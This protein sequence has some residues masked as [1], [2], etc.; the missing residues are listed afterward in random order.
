MPRQLDEDEERHGPQRR[1]I[2]TGTVRPKEEMIRFVV[3]PDGAV[4]PDIDGKLPGRGIWLSAA[5]DVVNTAVA[6]K[7]FA[8]A[9]RAKVVVPDDMGDRLAALLAQRC[10]GCLGMARRAGRVVNGYEKVRALLRAKRAGVL[11]EA[12]DGA[13]GG[14]G[15]IAALASGVPVV[16]L[17][18]SDELG[19]VL[20]R[21]AAVHV[22]ME[23]GPLA[24]R[25]LREAS[26]LA[27]FRPGHVDCGGDS[28]ENESKARV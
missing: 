6:K 27:G 19:A 1:C 4:V 21:D 3:A 13:A 16:S 15:K 7:L 25:L 5:R 10:L 23:P 8:K 22:A 2:A 9:A 14:R 28:R 24:E 26:R 12:V 11:L 20:G 17:F 18:T